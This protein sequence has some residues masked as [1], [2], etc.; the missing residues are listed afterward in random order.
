MMKQS[1]CPDLVA[2]LATSSFGWDQI[3]I[4][5]CKILYPQILS[6]TLYIFPDLAELAHHI[7]PWM[8]CRVRTIL[9]EFVD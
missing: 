6:F 2:L 7:W 3:R 9:L 5:P 4:Q 8:L 1:V